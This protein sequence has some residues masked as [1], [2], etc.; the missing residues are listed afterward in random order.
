[1]SFNTD[2]Q[3][4]KIID[5]VHSIQMNTLTVLTGSNG[6]GKSFVRKQMPFRVM[7]CNPALTK[8]KIRGV[9][10]SVSMQ[11]RTESRLEFGALSD[12]MHDL[13]WNPT[14]TS[15][16]H[17]IKSLFKDLKESGKKCYI[18][19]DEPEIG[20]SAESQLGIAMFIKKQYLENK[21]YLYGC[22]VI[23]HS[24]IVVDVLADIADFKNMNGY[25]TVHGWK[26]RKIQPTDFEKLEENSLALMR[27][28]EDRLHRRDK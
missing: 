8:D 16:Y 1:M 27:A 6:M 2:A 4:E 13:S 24:T 12:A 17:L 21:D 28:I 19:I 5:M 23:T 15:T 22:L 7:D 26:K 3:I 18:I 20:M 25:K 9:V 14:S 10:K 11:L